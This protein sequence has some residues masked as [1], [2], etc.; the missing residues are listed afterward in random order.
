MN[1]LHKIAIVSGKGGVGK[2]TTTINLGLALYKIGVNVILLDG[3]ITTPNLGLYLGVL[4]TPTSLN[5]A[6]R[7]EVHI[8]K[9]IY[10]HDS[11]LKIIPSDL[12]VDAIENIDFGKIKKTILD[13]DRHANVLLVDT[14]ATLGSETQKILEVVDEAIVVTNIDKGSLVDALKTI[15]TCKKIQTPVIGV[16][17]NKVKK[18]LDKKK[19]E[20]FLGIPIIGVIKH[21]N[22]FVK[23]TEKGKIYLETYLNT[24]VDRYFD[25]AKMFLGQSYE[26]KLKKEK[27]NSLFNYM[28]KQLGLFHKRGQ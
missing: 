3:N 9:A 19:I 18:R 4:K 1:K 24:N 22:K 8:S 15:E 21:D 28:L 20:E 16:I 14:A 6:L 12:A 11:G 2:T 25:V 26:K 10:Q 5:N 23:S 17:V 13:L 7:G 27:K